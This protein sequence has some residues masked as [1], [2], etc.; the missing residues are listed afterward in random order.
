MTVSSAGSWRA[1]ARGRATIAHAVALFAVVFAIYN[2]NGRE[3]G[4]WDSQPAKYAA[5]ELAR[6][7]TM[8]LDRVLMMTPALKGRHG[9]T[10]DQQGHVRSAY[11]FP[12]ILLAGA[13]AVTLHSTGLVDL[14]APPAANLVAK[15]T[16]SLLTALAVA[17]AFVVARRRVSPMPA[18]LV[19][20]GLGLGTN[21]WAVASQTLWQTETVVVALAAAVVCLAVPTA[22]LTTTRLWMGSMALG[23]AGAARP[24][25]APVIAVL[26]LSIAV[27]RGRL[28]DVV[29]NLPAIAISV[30]A[31]ALNLYWYGDPL[32]AAPRL[33]LL[34]AVHGVSGSFG[35][36]LDGAAGLLISPSRGLLVF[37]PIVLVALAGIGLLMREG[38]KA[39]LAWWAGAAAAQFALYAFYSVWWGGHTYGPRYCLDIL[40]LLVPLA[41]AG[42]PWVLAVAWRRRVAAVALAW[43]IVVAGTGA[44]VFPYDQW[45]N[46]PAGVDLNHERLW[47]WRDPQVVRCWRVGLSPSNFK[48]FG[49]HAFRKSAPK[50]L[51]P[52]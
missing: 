48:L 35:N 4:S 10:I 21:L 25:V 45:N 9:F 33:E 2:A 38:L 50:A 23:L 51:G 20:I 13:M 7:R 15:L 22:E 28:G 52:A 12:S 1:P 8:T 42:M 26:S 37:S 46:T 31:I 5:I 41:A 3:I 29:A 14:E 34:H 19:A 32:G 43:S 44:F 30:A 27:R 36:P 16:A 6:F 18:A 24:Q 17:M 47:D 40:P 11:P 49:E 39:D